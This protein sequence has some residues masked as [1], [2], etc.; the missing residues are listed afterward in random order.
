MNDQQT[1]PEA[2]EV[3]RTTVAWVGRIAGPALAWLVY[4]L[5][6]NSLD[7]AVLVPHAARSTAAT[8]VWMADWWM[9]EALPLPVTSLLPIVLFPLT[10]V[11]STQA[12]AGVFLNIV[13][14]L[15]IPL[16]M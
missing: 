13:G 9:T 12:R 14:A 3:R 2:S 16:A 15:L 10:G 8:G 4:Q 7:S 5:L 11:F 6:P 1:Y